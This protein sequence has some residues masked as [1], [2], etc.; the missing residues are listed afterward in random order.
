LAKSSQILAIPFGQGIGRRFD[1]LPV[2]EIGEFRN[3][4]WTTLSSDVSQ[5]IKAPYDLVI[6]STAADRQSAVSTVEKWLVHEP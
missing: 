5:S 4:R 2:A 1:K 3:A 6:L